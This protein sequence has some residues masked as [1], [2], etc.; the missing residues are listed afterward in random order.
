MSYGGSQMGGF[1]LVVELTLEGYVTS[2]ARPSRLHLPP[3]SFLL[4][5][6]YTLFSHLLTL[7]TASSS[8]SPAPSTS[9]LTLLLLLLEIH[10][11]PSSSHV[12]FPHSIAPSLLAPLQ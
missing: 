12:A 8:R 2:G 4:P 9:L 10:Q 6:M 1:C 11:S 7:H 3:P 5:A